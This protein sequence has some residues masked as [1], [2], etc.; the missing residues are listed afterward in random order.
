MACSS[1]KCLW[2]DNVH[3]FHVSSRAPFSRVKG[4]KCLMAYSNSKWRTWIIL[5]QMAKVVGASFSSCRKKI[6]INHFCNAYTTSPDIGIKEHKCLIDYT[7]GNEALESAFLKLWTT[8]KSIEPFSSNRNPNVAKREHVYAICCWLA[9][10]GDVIFSRN[11]T[12]I[13]G[14][15]VVYFEAAV[16]SSQRVLYNSLAPV[17]DDVISFLVRM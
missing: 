14:C 13:Q 16:S 15:V 4:R 8:L 9:V 1:T 7:I 6:E 12:T 5:S 2:Y 3:S 17:A 11:I 10:D